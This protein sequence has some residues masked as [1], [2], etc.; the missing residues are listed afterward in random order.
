MSSSTNTAGTEYG[1]GRGGHGDSSCGLVGSIFSGGCR[2]RAEA[3]A[4]RL[5]RRLT[6][7]GNAD[8]NSESYKTPSSVAGASVITKPITREVASWLHGPSEKT[9]TNS[10]APNIVN[11]PIGARVF[12]RQPRHQADNNELYYDFDDD[13]DDFE[14][15]P[16]SPGEEVTAA[17]LADLLVNTEILKTNHHDTCHC[18]P[19]GPRLGI[20]QDSE[21]E[22]IY[23]SP[24]S[25]TSPVSESSE[26]YFDPESSDV[27]KNKNE[28]YFDPVTS[29]ESEQ[30]ISNNLDDVSSTIKGQF[31]S[32]SKPLEN[33]SIIYR[34]DSSDSSLS[35]NKNKPLNR[36]RFDKTRQNKITV[37][38]ATTFSSED[39]LNGRSSR[40][41]TSP[42][43]ESLWSTFD[44][45]S[46]VSLKDDN[47]SKNNC[48]YLRKCLIKSHSDSEIPDNVIRT[49]AATNTL[50]LTVEK[51]EDDDDDDNDDDDDDNDDDDDDEGYNVNDFPSVSNERINIDTIEQ[52]DSSN[53]F[54][55]DNKPIANVS[56]ELSDT[57]NDDSSPTELETDLE[58]SITIPEIIERD[59]FDHS[60]YA[61][62]L[63][64]NDE[65]MV[66]CTTG[67][68]LTEKSDNLAIN[69]VTLQ[70]DHVTVLDDKVNEK[71]C[72]F[73]N[74]DKK[75][76]GS[77]QDDSSISKQKKWLDE[78]KEK[79]EENEDEQIETGTRKRE[80]KGKVT[81]EDE[82]EEE[83]EEDEEQLNG[84][85]RRIRRSSS[86]KTG[87]TPPGTPGRKKIVRF[88]DVLG[89]DLADVRTFLDEIPKIPNSAYNDLIYDDSFQ[90]ENSPLNLSLSTTS[91]DNRSGS[92][93]PRIADRTLVPLFQQPA[94]LSNF[95]DLI[96]ER[97]VCL[98]NVLVQDPISLSIQGTVRVLNLDFH[99]SVHIRYTLNSWKNYSDLQATYI[100][101]SCD[102]F[103]D[104]FSFVLYC[105]TLT[106]GQRLEFAVR[107]QCKGTQFWDNND[108]KNY[109][110]QCLPVSTRVQYVPIATREKQRD[111][112][113]SPIFY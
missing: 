44:D 51:N 107:F 63:N 91:W 69:E 104:K 65:L 15:E 110:F 74:K 13:L 24:V 97:K 21:S 57:I 22:C 20:D 35:S 80:G 10:V 32:S 82:E 56:T 2:G 102:G 79:E 42:S 78:G 41:T 30:L 9:T 83:E 77:N 52:S 39:S 60:I 85:P 108:G 96:R 64:L 1:R 25:G 29:S 98:E 112:D 17:E 7:L 61:S 71:T 45:D 31:S 3:F 18:S 70:I 111:R 49:F 48:N 72:D 103:S 34:E 40:E 73:L 33:I 12:H 66:E 93:V 16:S 4:R 59:E 88:A 95:L 50:P 101:N 75:C 81:T 90:K 87:K 11:N 68:R 14:Q 53:D 58:D 86:L 105:H 37:K 113:W 67:K 54:I 76:N 92:S 62:T 19:N 6:S 100:S 99:K 8:D 43:H 89:L 84:R 55:K 28:V 109:C 94:G 47:T 36:F 46:T 38:D 26:I 106:I 5:H 23:V 27:E